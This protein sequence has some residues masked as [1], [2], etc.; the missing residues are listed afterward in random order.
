[1]SYNSN[2]DYYETLGVTPQST[3]NEIKKAYRKL[4]GKHHPDKG[5]DAEEFKKIQATY[6]TLSDPDKK[7]AYD[8]PDPFGGQNP[9]GSGSPFGD[10]FSEVFGGGFGQR[11]QPA[12]N[13]DGVCD[14]RVDLYEVYNGCEKTIDVGYAKYKLTIP[15][16]TYSGTKFVMHGRGPQ[17]HSH[18]PPGDLICRVHVMNLPEWDRH[19]DDLI[20]KVQC[21]YFE[22][23]IGTVVRFPH[24][25]GK[26][27][28]VKIPAR[29]EP[30]SRLRLSGKGMPNPSNGRKGDLYVIVGVGSPT[31]SDDDI[32]KIKNFKDKEL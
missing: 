21:D 20:V 31:L 5:G 28:E 6:D 22:A 27:F 17:Q 16:G 12:R 1:M 9:F 23:M 11:R 10:I 2:M 24:I 7:N 25:D 18:L 32:R 3:P 13:P 15:A 19:N 26:T 30:D 29:S 4:A 14:V 8:N